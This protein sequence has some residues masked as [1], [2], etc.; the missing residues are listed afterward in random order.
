MNTKLRPKDYAPVGTKQCES[1][2]ERE[3]VM[4]PK[5]P[6]VICNGCKRVVI[7]NRK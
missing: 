5:G 4:T 1:K 7:D 2:C 3:V 6:L